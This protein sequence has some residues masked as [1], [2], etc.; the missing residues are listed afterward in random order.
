MDAEHY[1][2]AMRTQW[3]RSADGWSRRRDELQ[4]AA[5]PV[6]R[7]LIDAIEPQPGQLLLEL[8]AGPGDTG[9]LAAELVRPG[10]GGLI[11]S[12]FAEEMLDATRAR[13]RELGADNVEF[14][15]LE[16]EWLDLAT[17]SVDAVLCRW[18]FMLTA[19]PGAALREARRVIRPGGRLAL[20]AWDDPTRNA[21]A[22]LPTEVL[23]ERGLTERRDPAGPGMFAFSA[24]GRIEELLGDA[25]FADIEVDAVDFENRYPS[26]EAYW[27]TTMDL[28]RP[29]RDLV[30]GLD[31]GERAA[32]VEALGVRLEVYA[33]DDGGL[34]IPAR[35]LVAAAS[36]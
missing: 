10:G 36:A 16:M 6:S 22:T 34:A 31:E 2:D 20:A 23:L 30:E 13:A 1:R 24:P 29:F 33:R 27:D 9:L 14:R 25:G 12:D 5:L 8:A 32:V 17:A 18:G 11:S 7:W 26:V 19:D 28:S 35:T 3:S 4:R 15:V 21:W